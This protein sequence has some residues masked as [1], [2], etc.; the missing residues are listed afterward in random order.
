MRRGLLPCW[1][2][3]AK[4]RCGIVVS[5][6]TRVAERSTARVVRVDPDEGL[7]AQ[8]RDWLAPENV[9]VVY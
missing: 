5:T 1:V 2:R 8:L 4:R 9:R 6:A 7:L 3:F